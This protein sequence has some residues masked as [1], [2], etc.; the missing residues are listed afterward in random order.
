MQTL[1]TE[2]IESDNADDEK[3]GKIL[4]LLKKMKGKSFNMISD[5]QDQLFRD[6]ISKKVQGKVLNYTTRERRMISDLRVRAIRVEERFQKVSTQKT[7]GELLL[8]I[9]DLVKSL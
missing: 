2:I 5:R 4:N 9:L 1:L 8:K 7:E 6:Y 3:M